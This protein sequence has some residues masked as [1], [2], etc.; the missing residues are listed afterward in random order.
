MLRRKT[1]RST[2]SILVLFGDEFNFQSSPIT[3]QWVKKQIYIG[4]SHFHR[5]MVLTFF[6]AWI[7]LGIR[8]SSI[9]NTYR[10]WFSAGCQNL[11]KKLTDHSLRRGEGVSLLSHSIL[12]PVH[13]ANQ[14]LFFNWS[15]IDLQCINFWCIAKWF[16]YTYIYIFFS[17]MVY[18]RILNI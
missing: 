16:S 15:I 17:I 10:E 6:S 4:S 2:V 14:H 11:G 3:F 7:H 13:L 9:S 5:A 12:L 18:Y 8:H 1:L